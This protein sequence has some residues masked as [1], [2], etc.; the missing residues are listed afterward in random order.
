MLS[1]KQKKERR[2]MKKLFALKL[3]KAV[4]KNFWHKLK[5]IQE[6]D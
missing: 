6:V 3:I 5:L 4:A 1:P 2:I